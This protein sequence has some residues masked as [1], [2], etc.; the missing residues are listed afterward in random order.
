MRSA[1]TSTAHRSLLVGPLVVLLVGVAAPATAQHKAR[2]SADLTDHV[3]VGSPTIDVIVHGTREETEALARRYNVRI[4]KALRSGAVLRVTAGELEALQQDEAVDHLSA[5]IRYRS[6]GNVVAE[7]IGA[8]QVWGGTPLVKGLTGRGIGVAVIDSGVDP[9]HAA[10]AGRIAATVDFTG[11]DGV[12][13]FGHGTHVAATI[14][15]AQGRLVETSDYRGIAPAARII[16]LRVLGDDGSGLA[17]NV[18]EAIDW[19]IENR[20]AHN[21]RIINLS[22]GAPVLQSY[23]DDP[24][25]EAVDRA[26]AAGIVVVAAAGNFGMNKDGRLAWG[27]ITSPG[28][29]PS[30][31]TVGAIDTHGTAKRSDDTVARYSSRGPTRYDLVLKPDLVAP[32]S[33]VVSA[34]AAASYLSKTYPE[35]HVAGAGADA[36]MQLSGTSMAAAVVSGAVALVLE[37]MRNLNP[38][39]TKAV[40]QNTSSRI[41][42]EGLAVVGAGTLN[43][44][45]ATKL[46]HP[47]HSSATSSIGGERVLRSGLHFNVFNGNERH[48]L[49]HLKRLLGSDASGIV[50]STDASDTIIWSTGDTIIWSVSIPDTIIWSTSTEQG[51]I[52]WT[53]SSIDTII[54]STSEHSETIIWSTTADTIIWSTAR[55]KDTIIWST[56]SDDPALIA[57]TQHAS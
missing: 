24:V 27:G 41:E 29:H 47:G 7:S 4:R 16:N 51:T 54:W 50:W 11:G 55:L 18:I 46:L 28:N 57:T 5:D 13:R 14:A 37:Q 52:V 30:V 33:G 15:G 40:I 8:D 49:A 12:D 45:A 23:R 21:I 35:R 34:E 32:G 20:K 31:I 39:E 44:L 25:C 48:Q 43:V 56:F 22:L 19:A 38:R 9:Q 53:T 26:V 17:S 1:N 2:L 6:A 3:R 36:Y 10:L 42:S